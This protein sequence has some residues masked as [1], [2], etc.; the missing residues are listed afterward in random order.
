MKLQ[1]LSDMHLEM[2]FDGEVPPEDWA[3]N[4]PDLGADL[5]VLAGDIGVDDQGVRWGARE[6]ER[7]GVPAIYVPGNHE[8]YFGEHTERLGRVRAAAAGTPVRVLDNE[9]LVIGGVRVLGATLWA[10]LTAYSPDGYPEWDPLR[11]AR[12]YMNDYRHIRVREGDDERLLDPRDTVAW[13]AESVAWLQCELA[14]GH[15]GPTV[16]VTHHGPA[17]VCHKPKYGPQLGPEDNP[18]W[19]PLEHLFDPERVD[20]WVHGHTH[21]G[22]DTEVNSVRLVSNPSGY[23]WQYVAG[24]GYR[25]KELFEV[26]E[27]TT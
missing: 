26:R 3:F 18:Y 7:L 27:V 2:S 10:S 13:H 25:P 17:A 11:H 24:L 14:A 12:G 23:P 9:A 21:V 16:V 1:I 4:L 8:F 22:M 15:D 5:L 20:L 6:A 19:S